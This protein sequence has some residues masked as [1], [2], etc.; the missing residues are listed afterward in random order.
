MRNACLAGWPPLAGKDVCTR[1][2][3]DASMCCRERA[4][5]DLSAELRE[6][7]HDVRRRAL[8]LKHPDLCWKRTACLPQRPQRSKDGRKD[9]T[10]P[11]ET[12][13][14]GHDKRDR[15]AGGGREE[16][17]GW[18]ESRGR[19]RESVRGKEID[20]LHAPRNNNAT[21]SR[22]KSGGHLRDSCDEMSHLAAKSGDS[23][24]DG[25]RGCA[26]TRKTTA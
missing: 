23:A 18:V 14:R 9:P 15:R 22:R 8:H 6:H 21:L 19:K 16:S 12:S 11:G 13:K 10:A 3:G 17:E 25:W 4:S 26:G 7:H 20:H 5:P 1:A 2:A 24:V